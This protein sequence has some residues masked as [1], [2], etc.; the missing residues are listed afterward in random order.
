MTEKVREYLDLNYGMAKLRE[1]LSNEEWPKDERVKDYFD[2]VL[3]LADGFTGEE[4]KYMDTLTGAL[5]AIGKTL[6]E[7]SEVLNGELGGFKDIA[8]KILAKAGISGHDCDNC[9]DAG[10]CDMEAEVRAQKS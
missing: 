1:S 6:K 7:R 2:K 3:E 4:A 9:R 8:A 10:S 5:D